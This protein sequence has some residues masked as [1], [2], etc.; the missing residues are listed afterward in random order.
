MRVVNSDDKPVLCS[1][2]K[3]KAPFGYY[4]IETNCPSC[5]SYVWVYYPEEEDSVLDPQCPCCNAGFHIIWDMDICDYH[6]WL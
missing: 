1:S 4:R 6:V 5:L 3:V 2:L